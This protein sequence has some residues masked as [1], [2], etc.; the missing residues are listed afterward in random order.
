LL[1]FPEHFVFLEL[2]TFFDVQL[3]NPNPDQDEVGLAGTNRL[4]IHSGG[5]NTGIGEKLD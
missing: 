1:D 5:E 2:E 3:R 4:V